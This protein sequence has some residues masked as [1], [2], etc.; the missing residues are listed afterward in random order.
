M[1]WADSIIPAVFKAEGIAKAVPAVEGDS[2]QG[3]LQKA[4]GGDCAIRTSS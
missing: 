2:E 3:H 1:R 4:Q